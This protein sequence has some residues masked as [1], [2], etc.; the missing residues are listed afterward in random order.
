MSTPPGALLVARL[1]ERLLAR[2]Q[3]LALA[4][5]CTGGLV[6][7]LCT[8]RAGSSD[9]FEG[10]LVTYSNTLKQRLLGVSADTLAQAGAVSAQTVLAMVEGLLQATD[11]DW[12]LAVSGV[13][14]PGGG[15]AEKPVGTVWIAWAGRG[16]AVGASRFWFDGDRDAVRQAAAHAALAGL[17]DLLGIGAPQAPVG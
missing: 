10:G 4:E 15:S 3:R 17:C 1:A 12:G 11:A 14:G 5:S 7:K 6:A 13:A 16:Q 2:G 9:W 8:D